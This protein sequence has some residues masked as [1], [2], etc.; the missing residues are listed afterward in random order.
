MQIARI[1]ERIWHGLQKTVALFV[2]LTFLL[3]LL[4]LTITLPQS[5]VSPADEAAF[6]RWLAN[7]RTTLG[8]QVSVLASLGLLSLRSSW[9]T[10]SLLVALTFVAVARTVH[11]L[12]RWERIRAFGRAVQIVILAGVLLLLIGWGVQLRA[13]WIETGVSAWPDEPVTLTSHGISLTTPENPGWITPERYGLYL[14]RE[15]MG[16]GLE[17]RAE[18]ESGTRLPL[19]T[20]AQGESQEQLRLILTPQAP[21]AYFA[22]PANRL[23]FRLTLQTSPP[24]SQIRVQIYRGTGG[25]LLTET[26]LQGRGTLFA[27]NLRLQIEETPLPQLRVVYN[28]GAP[29]AAIGSGMLLLG[30]LAEIRYHADAV[31]A[32]RDHEGEDAV[33]EETSEEDES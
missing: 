23:I 28:P 14:I 18:D 5:P 22:L 29:L 26:T 31:G 9:W 32:E 15:E 25:E 8:A 6:L 13:G 10:R 30:A 4:L 16:L 7:I 1:L 2:I 33:I 27:D 24:D 11:L 19:L 21:D 20:S 3:L 12:E 17:I